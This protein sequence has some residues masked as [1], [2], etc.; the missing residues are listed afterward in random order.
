M[1]STKPGKSTSISAAGKRSLQT[2]LKLGSTRA[3]L[4]PDDSGHIRGVVNPTGRIRH[5]RR[6]RGELPFAFRSSR[7]LSVYGATG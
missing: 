4:S 6:L 2:P 1:T 3:T 7:S 5:G